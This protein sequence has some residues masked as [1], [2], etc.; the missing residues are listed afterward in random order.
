MTIG[1]F[2]FLTDR[3]FDKMR[4]ID[5]T[6]QLNKMENGRFKGRPYLCAFEK[7]KGV[8]WMIPI[9]HGVEKYRKIWERKQGYDFWSRYDTIMFGDVL[10]QERAILIQNMC[11][12]TECEEYVRDEYLD[13]GGYPVRLDEAT[14]E[15]VTDEAR[16]ILSKS[17]KY[18]RLLF[19]NTDGILRRLNRVSQGYSNNSGNVISADFTT[20]A[21]NGIAI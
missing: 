13:Y 1:N 3:Y 9:S 14:L 10:G 6:L 12:V 17:R 7:P 5:N 4:D 2:Y 21:A 8:Y 20:D 16:Y 15:M 18:P 19:T 11:P